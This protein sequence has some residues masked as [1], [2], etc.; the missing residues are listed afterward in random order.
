M[1]EVG[2]GRRSRKG[3]RKVMWVV[4]ASCVKCDVRMRKKN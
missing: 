3:K 2:G 1:K 4:E